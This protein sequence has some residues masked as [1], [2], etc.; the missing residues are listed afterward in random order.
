ML[1]ELLQRTE[2]QEDPHLCKEL[3]YVLK[4]EKKDQIPCKSEDHSATSGHD[5]DYSKDQADQG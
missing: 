1:G 5:A 2:R 3:L 4:S